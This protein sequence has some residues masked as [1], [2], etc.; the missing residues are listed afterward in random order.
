MKFYG[1]TWSF[2]I[3]YDPEED[4][5]GI[6]FKWGG[7]AVIRNLRGI[8]PHRNSAGLVIRWP[9]RWLRAGYY[10][11]PQ[12][13]CWFHRTPKADFAPWMIRHQ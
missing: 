1:D 5:W 4:R 13:T 9:L 10:T 2:L 12:V 6:I 3:G 7:R 11:R 8:L